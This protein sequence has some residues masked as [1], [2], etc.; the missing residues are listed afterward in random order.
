MKKNPIWWK[1][2]TGEKDAT[3]VW[4]IKTHDHLHSFINGSWCYLS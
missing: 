4:L 1:A 3:M 2:I